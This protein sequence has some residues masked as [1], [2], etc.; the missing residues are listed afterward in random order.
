MKIE[1]NFPTC[2]MMTIIYETKEILH[3]FTL[4]PL[5]WLKNLENKFSTSSLNPVLNAYII[6]L[7]I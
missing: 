3:N 5:T 6:V 1:D 4:L 2:P 7:K